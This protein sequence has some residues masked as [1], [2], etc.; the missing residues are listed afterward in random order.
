MKGPEVN[1]FI[2][3]GNR[4][5]RP[6][7]CPEGMYTVMKECWTYKWDTSSPVRAYV[8]SDNCA[9]TSALL[10]QARG[11]PWLQEGRGVHELLLQFHG[12]EDRVT[13]GASAETMRILSPSCTKPLFN[14]P[15]NSNNKELLMSSTNWPASSAAG[16][17]AS[18]TTHV[19]LPARVQPA[20]F[21]RRICVFVGP[22]FNVRCFSFTVMT[23]LAFWRVILVNI[24]C[25]CQLFFLFFF[26]CFYAKV[27][28]TNITVDSGI[29]ELY[30]IFQMSL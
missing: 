24:V 6:E 20:G 23:K 25:K 26:A 9:I 5:E 14:W 28:V 16:R 4:M 13:G 17:Q 18:V 2:E 15:L 11:S 22:S 10:R 1:Q 30:F 29:T 7:A 8:W 3:A 19:H 21:G 27:T 12:Y